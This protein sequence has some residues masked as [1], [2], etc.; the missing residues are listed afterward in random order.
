MTPTARLLAAALLATLAAT[1]HGPEPQDSV[2]L[3]MRFS[4]PRREWT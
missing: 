1:R 2:V 4:S 3:G